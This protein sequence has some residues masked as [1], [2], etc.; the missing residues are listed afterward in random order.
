M[1]V[2][3]SDDDSLLVSFLSPFSFA[4]VVDVIVIYCSSLALFHIRLSVM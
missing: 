1:L 3:G 4:V 2:F